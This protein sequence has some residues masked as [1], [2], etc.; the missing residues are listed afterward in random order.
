VKR[1]SRTSK[2][3]D[4]FTKSKEAFEEM[5][6]Q[7]LC[8]HTPQVDK[9]ETRAAHYKYEGSTTPKNGGKV[10]DGKYSK[11]ASA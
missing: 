4:I 1:A 6:M 5:D 8:Q 7:A 2:T 10:W 3:E 11:Q 9:R